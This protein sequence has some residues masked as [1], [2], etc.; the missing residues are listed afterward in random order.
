MPGGVIVARQ[1]HSRVPAVRPLNLILNETAS[2]ARIIHAWL[3]SG[4]KSVALGLAVV[5][6]LAVRHGKIHWSYL[7]VSCA[8]YLCQWGVSYRQKAGV[9]GY[10]APAE[11]FA[12]HNC[13]I[14]DGIY[15]RSAVPS[16]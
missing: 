10:S 11:A 6:L 2:N 15:S 1:L 16:L 13:L 14:S 12:L 7:L 3:N 5:P 8:Y 9:G 4:I